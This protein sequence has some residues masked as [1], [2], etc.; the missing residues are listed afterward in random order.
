MAR[1]QGGHMRVA[2]SRLCCDQASGLGKSEDIGTVNPHAHAV[3]YIKTMGTRQES[4]QD[5]HKATALRQ[6]LQGEGVREGSNEYVLS[7]MLV[8]RECAHFIIFT[9]KL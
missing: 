3:L 5:E 7:F 6:L 1:G 9:V 4:V 2:E 8:L